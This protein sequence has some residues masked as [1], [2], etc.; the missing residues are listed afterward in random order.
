MGIGDWA[1]IPTPDLL[2]LLLLLIYY[3]KNFIIFKIN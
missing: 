2:N 1:Q 3:S